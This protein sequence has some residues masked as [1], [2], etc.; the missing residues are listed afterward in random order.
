MFQLDKFPHLRSA[1]ERKGSQMKQ[2][3]RVTYFSQHAEASRR[4][5]DPQT[6]SLEDW[7]QKGNGKLKTQE[8]P[9][10]RPY[11]CRDSWNSPFSTSTPESSEY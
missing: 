10:M 8:V 7:L 2:T 6:A 11:D 9:K 4:L 1:L 3:E 5:Q